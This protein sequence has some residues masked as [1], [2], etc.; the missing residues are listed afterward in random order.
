[1]RKK[2]SIISILL[3]TLLMVNVFSMSLFSTSA[4]AAEQC[5]VPYFDQATYYQ[6]TSAVNCAPTAGKTI[7]DY[8][9]YQRGITFHV[10]WVDPY[11]SIYNFMG[12]TI[13][14]T[15]RTNIY[16]GLINYA[17]A[18]GSPV[19]GS[20]YIDRTQLSYDVIKACIRNGHPVMI[21]TSGDKVYGDH[22]MVVFGY[23]DAGTS[24]YLRVATGLNTSHCNWI[25]YN[26]LSLACAMEFRW[27]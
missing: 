18:A 4:Y 5:N 24:K 6:Q 13:Y 14:G 11:Y 2:K 1:M 16:T 17:D 12:T 23:E 27:N 21:I 20:C 19:T 10:P 15:T 22:A 7:I 8:W 25:D 3:G 26:T 9:Q